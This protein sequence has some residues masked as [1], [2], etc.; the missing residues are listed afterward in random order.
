MFIGRTDAEAEAL[1]LWPPDARTDSLWPH[2]LQHANLRCPSLSPG[3]YSNS[4]LLSKWCHPIFSSSVALFSSCPQ[5]FPTS[6]S[7]PM[8]QFFISGGQSIGVSASASVLA[9]S[10]QDWFPFRTDWLDLLAVQ[11]TL[12][13]LLQHHSSKASI[14]QCLAFFMVQLLHPY[15]T[16][17]K[18]IALYMDLCWQR[19]ISAF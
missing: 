18:T 14:L 11:G 9:M 10:I 7:F 13:S 19:D 3:V 5:S 17:G 6:E 2:G 15:M 12:K 16:T 4:C 8:S 1:I